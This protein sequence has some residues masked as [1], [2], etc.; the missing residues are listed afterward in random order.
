M[1]VAAALCGVLGGLGL[2]LLGTRLTSGGIG[3]LVAG[4]LRRSSAGWR[5]LPRNAFLGGAGMSALV[6][7]SG[8]L[9]VS[10][11][12]LASRLRL[13]KDLAVA[14]A[15]GSS[16]GPVMIAV[17]AFLAIRVPGMQAFALAVLGASALVVRFRPALIAWGEALA[18]AGLIVLGLALLGSGCEALAAQGQAPSILGQWLPVFVYISLG[19]ALA[20]TLA[21][22]AAAVACFFL[23]GSAGLLDGATAA[24]ALI[25]AMASMARPS[26]RM[27]RSGRAEEREVAAAHSTFAVLAALLGGALLA[28]GLTVP[29]LFDDALGSPG[30]ALLLFL[31]LA[32]G[33]A[34]L[35]TWILEEPLRRF[36]QDRLP[37]QENGRARRGPSLTPETVPALPLVGL[38]ASMDEALRAVCGLAHKVLS[39]HEPSSQR[40]RDADELLSVI[41]GETLAIRAGLARTRWPSSAVESVL[42]AARWAE[43]LRGMRTQLAAV[44][45]EPTLLASDEFRRRL[46]HL[47]LAVVQLIEQSG[48]EHQEHT[49][50]ELQTQ[51]DQLGNDV[52]LAC[53]TNTLP[54]AWPLR[55]LS[56]NPGSRSRIRRTRAETL[57][58]IQH[59][60]RRPHPRARS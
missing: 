21:S 17:L 34:A 31:T 14:L 47:R 26:W 29:T 24:A 36:L 50:Q 25:G 2:F 6:G 16:L 7:G 58:P 42:Q 43:L 13:R 23:A 56:A 51:I 53:T 48:S 55:P 1:G 22:P 45:T 38:A 5:S 46:L 27:A 59:P 10:A 3:V 33:V 20:L 18:G 15:L 30:V 19:A 32:I 40:W 54:R 9:P 11:L 57:H 35:I 49:S 12:G 39:G 28:W 8:T 52:F 60:P 41:E 37:P 4:P 44:P